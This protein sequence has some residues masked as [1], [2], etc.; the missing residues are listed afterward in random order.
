MPTSC[1][2]GGSAR[3]LRVPAR[4][5]VPTVAK[6]MTVLLAG[7]LAGA[8]TPARADTPVTIK[9]VDVTVN[10]RDKEVTVVVKW[11]WA[12]DADKP[13]PAEITVALLFPGRGGARL[14]KEVFKLRSGTKMNQ[15]SEGAL[16]RMMS[17]L[18]TTDA[19]GRKTSA[20]TLVLHF[21]AGKEGKVDFRGNGEFAFKM[22][23][24][25]GG[26]GLPKIAARGTVSVGVFKED[27]PKADQLKS[28]SYVALSDVVETAY[29][30]K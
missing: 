21:Q 4:P 20:G 15:V 1:R 23:L 7:V 19:G 25:G 12:K 13:D 16:W 26:S 28:T 17:D 10:E 5:P 8:A 6:W 29:G 18:D 22:P 9:G 11:T 3:T 24:E 14:G 30:P 2:T 27:D